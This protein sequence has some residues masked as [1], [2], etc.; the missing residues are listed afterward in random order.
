LEKAESGLADLQASEIAQNR[1]GNPWKGLAK[2]GP[3][4][5]KLG[6]KILKA[7]RPA[8]ARPA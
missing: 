6:K 8:P 7:W 3:E 4:L 5:E 1:Q 2:K